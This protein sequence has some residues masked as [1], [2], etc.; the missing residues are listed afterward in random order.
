M[1]EAVHSLPVQVVALAAAPQRLVPMP[2]HLIAEG[3]HRVAVAGHRVVVVVPAQDAGE[4][5]SLLRDGLMRA[6]PRLGLDRTQLCSHPLRV[7]DALD[8]EASVRRLRADVR[9]A[10]ESERFRLAQ[11]APLA[12]ASSEP[13]ELDQPRLLRCQLQ[14]EPREPATKVVKE[15]LRIVLMLEADDVVVGLCRVASYAE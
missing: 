7:G 10:E 1:R 13:P 11:A 5:V 9:E 6:P 2:G 3:V 12:V 14:T 8:Q 15:P 4:P